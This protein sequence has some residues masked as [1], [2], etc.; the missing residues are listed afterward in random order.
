MAK[1]R[2]RGLN[3]SATIERRL[4]QVKGRAA[5][6]WFPAQATLEGYKLKELEGDMIF[7]YKRLTCLVREK[8]EEESMLK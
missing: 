5:E 8:L 2:K 4:G 7:S 6:I 3:I 1:R